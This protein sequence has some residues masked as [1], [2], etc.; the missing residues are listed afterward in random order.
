MPTATPAFEDC[1]EVLQLS[2]NADQDTIERVYRVLVKRYH[3]DNQE[4]GNSDKFRKVMEAYRV[5]SDPEK[6]AAYDIDYDEN[7]AVVLKIFDEA[8]QPDGYDGDRRIF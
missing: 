4:T 6:R 8:S 5:L 7:R 3:P 1:Y 2:P